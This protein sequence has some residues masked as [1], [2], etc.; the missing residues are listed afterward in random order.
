MKV[1]HVIPSLAVEDGGPSVAVERMANGLA[2]L[3]V[4]VTI[5]TTS[6]EGRNETV[7][8]ALADS[9]QVVACK[10]NLQPYKISWPAVLWL[11]S[12]IGNFDVVHIHAVFSFLSV[13]AGNI[14]RKRGLPYIVRPLGVLNKWGMSSGR[15]VVKRISYAAFE[16]KVL[17]DASLVHYTSEREADETRELDPKLGHV[18]SFVLPVPVATGDEETSPGIFFDLFP[19]LRNRKLLLFLSRFG[20]QKGSELVIEAFAQLD[21][22]FSDWTLVMAGGGEAAYE[23]R[24]KQLAETSGLRGN[25]TWVGYLSGAQKWSAFAASQAYILP[26]FSESFGIAAA[27]AL[28]AGM[29]ALLSSRI[30]FAPEAASHGG[31]RLIDLTVS[32]VR[33]GLEKVLA[34]AAA[35]ASMR[36]AARRFACERF[37]VDGITTKLL[38]HYQQIAGNSAVS[39]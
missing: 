13:V 2:A 16:S 12:Q 6:S 25:I 34:D 10:R 22:R 33:G 7:K 20:P 26:S 27:E 17:R 9:I 11:R 4:S 14:A 29:P 3:G 30:P 23:R 39:L 5:L 31:A 38:G 19:E 28:V 37:T 1:L 32:S 8:L 36:V 18:P 15:A 21:Q 24:L 35:R